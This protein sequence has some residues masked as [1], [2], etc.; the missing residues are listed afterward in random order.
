MGDFVLL[1]FASN[2][3]LASSSF[4]SLTEERHVRQEVSSRS[5]GFDHLYYA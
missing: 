1:E 2:Q 4:Q 3:S 5:Q